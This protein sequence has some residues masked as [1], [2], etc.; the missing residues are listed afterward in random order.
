[1]KNSVV[2]RRWKKAGGRRQQKHR[3]S[4]DCLKPTEDS[5]RNVAAETEGDSR[6]QN[7]ESER[8]KSEWRWQSAA[9]SGKQAAECDR[10]R[11]WQ[12]A[13]YG[14][15]RRSKNWQKA[16]S[17]RSPLQAENGRRKAAHCRKQEAEGR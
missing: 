17:G 8:R 11:K 5:R 3:A 16:E 1:M 13:E 10:N 15:R 7:A 9:E 4:E 2:G 12:K 6:W 14:I